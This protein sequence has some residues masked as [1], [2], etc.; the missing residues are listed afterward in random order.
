MT[1]KSDYAIAIV[2]ATLSNWLKNLAPLFQLMR[3]KTKTNHTLSCT[4]DFS[5]AL[6]KLQVIARNFDWF[7]ALF[8]PVVIGRCNYFGIVFSTDFCCSKS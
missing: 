2:I 3:S 8:P 6:S 1:V 7:I 4:R 5:R